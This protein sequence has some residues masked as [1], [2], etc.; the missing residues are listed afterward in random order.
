VTDGPGTLHLSREQRVG[1]PTGDDFVIAILI[2]SP[3]RIEIIAGSPTLEWKE[4]LAWEIFFQPCNEVFE[5]QGDEPV[6]E[7]EQADGIIR[8]V[9]PGWVKEDT[10]REVWSTQGP[11]A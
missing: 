10:K 7:D 8:Q 2:R 4:P 1:D 9:E 11:R 6:R 5:R 3:L